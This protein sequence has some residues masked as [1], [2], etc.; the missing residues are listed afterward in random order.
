MVSMA[1]YPQY[2]PSKMPSM[3]LLFFVWFTTT[4]DT[5]DELSDTTNGTFDRLI[6]S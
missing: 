1:S 4:N 6:R 2:M 3:L 5:V